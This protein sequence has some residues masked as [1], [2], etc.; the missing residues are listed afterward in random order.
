MLTA[1][2][3]LTVGLLVGLVIG[4]V[5]NDWL[6]LP[7]DRRRLEIIASELLAEARI[8]ALTRSTLAAM[9]VVQHHDGRIAP[10]NMRRPGV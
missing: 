1:L 9:R 4:L 6:L 7:H 10:R 2:V 8:D 3:L 5:A